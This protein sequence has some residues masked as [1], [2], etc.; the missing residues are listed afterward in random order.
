MPFT[1]EQTERLVREAY[2]LPI[3][4]GNGDR[5]DFVQA[6]RKQ[7]VEM[8]A[9]IA[10]LDARPEAEAKRPAAAGD[11]VAVERAADQA[12][13]ESSS[14]IEISREPAAKKAVR[15]GKTR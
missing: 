14:G 4:P 13:G 11:R 3:L 8:F 12:A 1:K 15:R 7:L 9:Q 5:I 2:T 10:T 6:H